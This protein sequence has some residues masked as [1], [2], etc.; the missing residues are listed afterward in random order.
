MTGDWEGLT[1]ELDAW[2]AMDRTATFWWRDDDAVEATPALETLLKVADASGAPA[3]VAVV[4]HDA[5]A[6][7]AARL[8]GAAGIQVLQHGYAHAN[9]APDGEKKTEL[10]PHRRADHVIADLATGQDRLDRLF[11]GLYLPVLVPPWNRIAPFL[12]PVLPEMK[13]LGLST[14]APRKR[15]EPVAGFRQTNTHV[16]LI[17]WRGGRG[18]VG[19]AV[20][21]QA[22]ISHLA[23]RREGRADPSE[24]TGI[25]TH[26][27]VQ[28]SESWH[29]VD[30]LFAT[31]RRHGAARIMSAGE[32]FGPRS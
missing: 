12:V 29:F 18:F 20:A 31:L 8:D 7:L 16:D 22:A 11:G 28:D 13:F 19:P 23:D 17:D 26:H 14:F 21:L 4:P 3:A 10:G 30:A 5:T 15:A 32:I 24:A 6:A 9:H 25:L 27:L 1:R 2:A